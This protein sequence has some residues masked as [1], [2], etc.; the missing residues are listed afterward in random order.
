MWIVSVSGPSHYGVKVR[1]A[2]KS[3]G[4]NTCLNIAQASVF[5]GFMWE[6]ET[7]QGFFSGEIK[8]LPHGLPI[9]LPVGINLPGL[10]AAPGIPDCP[11]KTADLKR[12]MAQLIFPFHFFY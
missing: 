5:P 4:E 1:S 12:Q 6:E 7:S 8:L 10:L 3:S 11:P 9:L 2:H